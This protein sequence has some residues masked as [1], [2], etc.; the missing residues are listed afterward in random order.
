MTA[1]RGEGLVVFLT[2]NDSVC[3]ECGAELGRRRPR[4]APAPGRGTAGAVFFALQARVR[5]RHTAY[6]TLLAS[7]ADR[8]EARREVSGEVEAIMGNWQAAATGRG[9]G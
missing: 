6:D 2:L 4:D 9:G 7:G 5:H 1:G 3:S 8:R